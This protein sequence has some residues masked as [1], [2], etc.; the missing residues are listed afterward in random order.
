MI[1][2]PYNQYTPYTNVVYSLTGFSV[3]HPEDE[4][5]P[6]F[7]I[8][9]TEGSV[10]LTFEAAKARIDK[11]VASSKENNDIIRWQSF[12]IAE[13][14]IGICCFD[15]YDGQKRWSFSGKGE[16]VAHKAISTL[17]DI[18]GNCQ[19]YWGREESECKFKVGD[20]VEIT[21]YR[22]AQLG[23]S[24]QL[25]IISALPI[26]FEH[27]RRRLPADQP[28][29]PMGFHL[30]YSDDNYMVIT[31]DD[32]YPEPVEVTDCFPAQTLPLDETIVARLK[33]KLKK[34]MEKYIA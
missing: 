18:N 9:Q 33:E 8:L 5:Y 2:E 24:V 7:H 31:L 32:E 27:C 11:I 28:S 26:N 16:L 20:V 29:E 17:E 4:Y 6:M 12:Y 1:N 21:S 25:G 30:D 23:R 3:R 19:I 13:V 15:V 14:P 34:N 22:G 10:H